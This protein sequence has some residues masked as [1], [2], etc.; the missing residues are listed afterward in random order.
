MNRQTQSNKK[1]E[2]LSNLYYSKN[3]FE[4]KSTFRILRGNPTINFL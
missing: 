2:T 1:E 3:L 4:T